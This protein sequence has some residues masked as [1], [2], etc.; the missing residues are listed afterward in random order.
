M[1]IKKSTIILLF[2][3]FLIIIL[4]ITTPTIKE[5]LIKNNEDY[6]GELDSSKPQNISIFVLPAIPIISIISPENITYTTNTILLNYS[7]K[8][9]LNPIW[10]NLDNTMNIT[11]TSPLELTATQGSHILY[12][13]ANNTYDTSVKIISFFVDLTTPTT[14]PQP[15]NNEGNR[16]IITPAE[17]IENITTCKK[18]FVCEPWG[19]CTN[20]LQY[21]SCTDINYCEESYIKIENKTC[22]IEEKPIETE[23]PKKSSWIWFII[24][25]IILILII[26]E[27]IREENNE[28]TILQ[29]LKGM[30][31]NPQ[32][33]SF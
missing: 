1:K 33:F 11:I 30:I 16:N 28:K 24:I 20:N 25:I 19:I 21:R 18:S 2:I 29:I 6:K 23:T 27:K 4:A 9:T 14:P 10:Y 8:N 31:Y 22:I 15:K 3:I 17:G 5:N 26:L 13:Y 7:I 12:L 32:L